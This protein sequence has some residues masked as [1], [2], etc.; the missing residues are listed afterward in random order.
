MTLLPLGLLSPNEPSLKVCWPENIASDHE[1]AG[2][3]LD[4]L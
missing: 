4:R 1:D 2:M 3:G